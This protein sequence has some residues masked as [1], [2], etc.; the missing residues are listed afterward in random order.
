MDFSV[1]YSIDV[2]KVLEEYKISL[3][4][5]ES[6]G[7]IGTLQTDE[8]YYG[9]GYGELLFKYLSKKIAEIGHDV[10]APVFES[11]IPSSSLSKLG[12]KP[13]TTDHWVTSKVIWSPADE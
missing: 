7:V 8:N 9:H 5:S 3:N 11:N 4:F 12:F 10:Y 6:T 2:V 13:I 1:T